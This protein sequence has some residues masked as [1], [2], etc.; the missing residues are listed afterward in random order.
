MAQFNSDQVANFLAVPPVFI[1]P[2]E[3]GVPR[4]ARWSFTAPVGNL[5]TASTV[6]LCIVPAGAA[7]IGGR[8]ANDA[9]S[10][11]GGDASVQIG[12][13]NRS[14]PTTI[15]SATFFLGTTSVDAAGAG[16][17]ADTMALNYGYEPSVDI[18][19]V[20]TVVTEAWVAAGT[21]NGYVIYIPA[22]G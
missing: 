19:L 18:Y 16:T 1:D 14:T 5:A 12:Y 2:N 4:I 11:A 17:F 22:G 6:L 13:S 9:L 15:V 21:F 7:I 20:A 10:S 8:R 3:H